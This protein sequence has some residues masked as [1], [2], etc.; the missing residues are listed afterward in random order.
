MDRAAPTLQVRDYGTQNQT[1]VAYDESF[2]GP[3]GAVSLTKS[4][5]PQFRNIKLEDWKVQVSTDMH[6]CKSVS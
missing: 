5:V 3:K 1:Q 6:F 2:L 4:V